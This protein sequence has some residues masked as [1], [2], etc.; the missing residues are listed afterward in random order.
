M[1]CERCRFATPVNS[2]G[3]QDECSLFDKYGTI[4]K[5]GE[6]GCTCNYNHLASQ[7]NAHDKAIGEYATEWGLENDF[8]N[9]GWDMQ[10]TIN[11]A[12]HMVGLT[13]MGNGKICG[14]IYHRHGRAFYKAYRNYYGGQRDDFDYMTHETFGYMTRE[15]GQ[16]YPFYHLTDRGLEWLSRQLKVKITLRG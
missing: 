3:Y 9:H 12:A 1:K 11:G 16:E 5:D 4:W 8:E 14:D 2:E 15:E 6:Y 10:K 7:E 13:L